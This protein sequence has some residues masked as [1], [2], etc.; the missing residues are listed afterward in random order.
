MVIIFDAIGE[1]ADVPSDLSGTSESAFSVSEFASL[2]LPHYRCFD[3]GYSFYA[4]DT[5]K[6]PCGADSDA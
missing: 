4:E 5:I 2:P 1:K 6:G 3:V